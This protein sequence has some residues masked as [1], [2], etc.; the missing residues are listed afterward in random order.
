MG[1]SDLITATPYTHISVDSILA[2]PILQDC[3][4]VHTSHNRTRDSLKFKHTLAPQTYSLAAPPTVPLPSA[5]VC[6]G[7]RVYHERVGPGHLRLS[8][9]IIQTSHRGNDQR[10]T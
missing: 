1:L 10:V 3:S 7:H 9:F 6:L 2:P 8:D 4:G 5:M